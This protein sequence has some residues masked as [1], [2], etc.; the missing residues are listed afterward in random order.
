M[1]SIIQTTLQ[2]LINENIEQYLIQNKLH[3]K[4]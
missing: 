4:E 2:Y 1:K 3:E